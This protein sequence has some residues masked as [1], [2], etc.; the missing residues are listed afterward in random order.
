MPNAELVKGV[1]KVQR[2]LIGFACPIFDCVRTGPRAEAAVGQWAWLATGVQYI[3][4]S[5]RR[6]MG[7]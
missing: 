2:R 5:L 4:K 7:V 3:N 1:G 6:E